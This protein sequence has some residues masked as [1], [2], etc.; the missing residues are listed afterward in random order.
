MLTH[1]QVGATVG[2]RFADRAVIR[3]R[4]RREGK[5]VPEDRLRVSLFGA[6]I[7]LPLS[8]SIFGL[9]TQF[10]PGK[11]GL[12]VNLVCLFMNGV[13]VRAPFSKMGVSGLIWI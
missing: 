13:G 11:F 4:L 7:L 6:L 2:G 10:F 9:T 5:W 1:S 8:L 3:G 12:I